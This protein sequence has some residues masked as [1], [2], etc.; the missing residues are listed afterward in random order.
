MND[1]SRNI[2]EDNIFTIHI[3]DNMELRNQLRS[4]LVE[5]QGKDT[6][7]VPLFV[8]WPEWLEDGIVCMYARDLNAALCKAVRDTALSTG[9][10]FGANIK[11]LDKQNDEDQDVIEPESAIPPEK[12]FEEIKFPELKTAEKNQKPDTS[13]IKTE[14]PEAIETVFPIGSPE[15]EESEPSEES[16]KAPEHD[17]HG[18]SENHDDSE[19]ETDKKLTGP[20]G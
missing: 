12:Q 5:A 2:P 7:K 1:A 18:E 4:G 20:D 3:S 6:D 10:I 13:E 15:T 19:S 9:S 16:R 14:S 8:S 17:N 11:D